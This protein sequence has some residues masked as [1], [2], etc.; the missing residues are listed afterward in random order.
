[1]QRKRKH[2]VLLAGLDWLPPLVFIY[3]KSKKSSRT[4]R[5]RRRIVFWYISTIFGQ[6]R[7]GMQSQPK[8]KSTSTMYKENKGVNTSSESN[9]FLIN[10]IVYVLFL[11]AIGLHHYARQSH[12]QYSCYRVLLLPVKKDG[13]FSPPNPS[14][15]SVWMPRKSARVVSSMHRSL[16]HRSCWW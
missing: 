7:W 14:I 6:I 8:E 2:I 12:Y 15:W 13:S 11:P 5:T 1:M 10:L 9:P 4:K 16:C 3:N